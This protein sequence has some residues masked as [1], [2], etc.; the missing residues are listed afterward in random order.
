MRDKATGRRREELI[1]AD[2]ISVNAEQI[3]QKGQPGLS[4][5]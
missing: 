1:K 5:N 3:S 4:P 2:D